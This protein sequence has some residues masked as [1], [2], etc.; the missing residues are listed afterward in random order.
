[1]TDLDLIHS[2]LALIK[3]SQEKQRD[4]FEKHAYDDLAHFGEMNNHLQKL[5]T[6]D[7]V[8]EVLKNI[9]FRNGKTAFHAIVGLSI[10][11]TAL[12]VIAGGA[13]TVLGWIGFTI[14]SK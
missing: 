13:K 7:D 5:A 12:V 9:L 1:M 4:S 14:M 11:I 8:E 2:E 6:K 10:L 3:E